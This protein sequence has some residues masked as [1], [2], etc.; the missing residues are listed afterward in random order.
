MSANCGS[1]GKSQGNTKI[2]RI[3]PL[4]N[5]EVKL[6]MKNE[7]SW[8]SI[9]KLLSYFSLKQSGRLGKLHWHFYSHTASMS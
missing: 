6:M 4:G 8:Q 2:S 7:I 5:T 3:H 1:G 9:R